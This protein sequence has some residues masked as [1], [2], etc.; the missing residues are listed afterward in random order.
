MMFSTFKE[1]NYKEGV[2]IATKVYSLSGTLA[3]ASGD[4]QRHH[5]TC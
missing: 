3:P 5:C 4:S 1:R 2:V